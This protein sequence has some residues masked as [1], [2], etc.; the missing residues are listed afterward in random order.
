M[1]RLNDGLRRVARAP[2]RPFARY[3]NRRFEDVHGHLDNETESVRARLDDTLT[4]TQVLQDRVATD[5]EVISELTIGFE[6]LADRFV[7]RMDKVLA[8]L[9]Q[10]VDRQ[11]SALSQAHEHA[12]VDEPADAVFSFAA[13]H[14]HEPGEISDL[15]ERLRGWLRRDGELVL[16]L[17]A[18]IVTNELLR[19]WE[20]RERRVLLR[21]GATEW[22]TGTA[23]EMA[24]HPEAVVVLRLATTA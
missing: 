11:P 14:E 23:A 7:D 9:E 16:S 4:T 20:V 13:S 21:G 12:I 17:P 24:D 1:G 8:A 22:A 5:V 2:V 6:R 10:L 18:S 3:F 15:L 19:G